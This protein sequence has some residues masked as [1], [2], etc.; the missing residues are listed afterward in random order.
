MKVE[1]PTDYAE[2][3]LPKARETVA[4]PVAKKLF[5]NQSGNERLNALRG[6]GAAPDFSAI[7]KKTVLAY[8]HA[9][10]KDSNL[11]DD[12]A[13]P[14]Y[15]LAGR[16]DDFMEDMRAIEMEDTIFPDVKTFMPE[17]LRNA[18]GVALWTSGHPN[19]QFAKIDNSK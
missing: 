7:F 2:G 4:S 12:K 6:L 8:A 14:Y 18:D 1:M 19:Y 17:L 9:L 5:D 13:R 15:T 16:A 11:L 10:G 3:L